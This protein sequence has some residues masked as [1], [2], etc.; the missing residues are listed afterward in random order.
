MNNPNSKN[1]DI[2]SLEISSLDKR[3]SRKLSSLT[4]EYLRLGKEIDERVSDLV[5]ARSTLKEAVQEIIVALSPDNKLRV[6]GP[7]WR[8]N[9]TRNSSTF[10]N[11]NKLAEQGVDPEIIKSSTETKYGDWYVKIERIEEKE[12]RRKGREKEE[13]K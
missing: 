1:D 3:L 4:N 7:G 8:A 10:L 12:K 5:E 2:E 9:K 11:P 13:E 6:L